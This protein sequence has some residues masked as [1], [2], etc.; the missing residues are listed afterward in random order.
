M[1]AKSL[2]A[3]A[4]QTP[5]VKM[6]LQ[7][8]TACVLKATLPSPV[9]TW[10]ANKWTSTFCASQTSIASTTPNV[11]KPNASVWRDSLLKARFASTS[12]SAPPILVDPS[13]AAKTLLAASIASARLDTLVLHRQCS[14]RRPVTR[15][16]AESMLSAS[17]TDRRPTASAKKAGLITLVILLLDVLVR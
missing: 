12:T 17:P 2:S 5:F 8:T 9:P 4:A 10:L 14:A 6:Q 15:S 3:L 11:L 7:A 1:N 16:S 13:P